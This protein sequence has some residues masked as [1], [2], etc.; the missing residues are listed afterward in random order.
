MTIMENKNGRPLIFKT[1]EELK[2]AVEKYFDEE[3]KPTLAG[4]A[5]A[6]GINRQT[7]YNYG[8]RD[9]FLDII[10]RAREKVEATYEQR[11]VYENNPTGVIFALKNMNWRDKVET[12]V[13][14]KEGNDVLVTTYQI[15]DNHRENGKLVLNGN[16]Q[17]GH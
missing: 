8:E 16:G 4:L 17:N 9:D 11:L 2:Q 6:L 12:G 14:D 1:P 7:L 3:K 5:Y 13:T 15:P 10:K